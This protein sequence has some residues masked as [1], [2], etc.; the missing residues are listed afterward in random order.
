[1]KIINLSNEEE[2]IRTFFKLI[3][4][5]SL[6][7]IISTSIYG[8]LGTLIQG[9]NVVGEVLVTLEVPPIEVFPLFYSKPITWLSAAILALYFSSLE[10]GKD[11]VMQ[12]RKFHRDILKF[13]AFFVCAM[14]TYEVLFNFTLWG[15]LIASDSILGE[16]N[17][18]IIK[19]TFPNP[20]TP[21]NIVFATKLFTVLTIISAYSFYY[22]QRIESK[23]NERHLSHSAP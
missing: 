11:M 10:L 18:D 5:I 9:G 19:N 22:L 21:W 20:E 13:F 2:K 8:I 1:M 7:V 6:V 14:A 15:G 16:L 23:I 17:V 12:W 4:L 3:S